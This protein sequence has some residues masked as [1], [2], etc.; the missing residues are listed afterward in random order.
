[1]SFTVDAIAPITVAVAARHPRVTVGVYRASTVKVVAT[2]WNVLTDW[3]VRVAAFQQV[4]CFCLS[5]VT[6]VVSQSSNSSDL[7]DVTVGVGVP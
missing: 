7:P 3:S 2:R 4:D 1:M 6:A 5:T